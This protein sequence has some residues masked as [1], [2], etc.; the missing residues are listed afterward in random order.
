[1]ESLKFSFKVKPIEGFI[2]SECKNCTV[3]S[4]EWSSRLEKRH[5]NTNPFTIHSGYFAIPP[6]SLTTI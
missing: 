1:M 5:I 4:F 2:H 3:K 6:H